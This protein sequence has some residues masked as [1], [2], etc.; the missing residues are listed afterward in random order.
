MYACVSVSMHVCMDDF[1]L[2][3]VY[4]CI[5]V[6]LYEKEESESM[7]V[8]THVCVPVL[9]RGFA[10]VVSMMILTSG[11]VSFGICPVVLSSR[12]QWWSPCSCKGS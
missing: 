4:E 8:R 2:F 7:C 5:F 9:R 6:C 10:R 1:F 12:G 3:F 11:V